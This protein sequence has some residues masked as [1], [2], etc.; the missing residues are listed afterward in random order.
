V[1]GRERIVI[2]GGGFAGLYAAR[3]LERTLP[4][5]RAQVTLVNNRNYML[6]TPQLPEVAAGLIGP[7]DIVVPLREQL[8]RT[9]LRI[10]QVTGA[11]LGR[12]VLSVRDGRGRDDELP[13]DYL[14]VALGSVSRTLPIPGL[15]ERAVGFKTIGEALTLR[16]RVILSLEAAERP[17][18][19]EEERAALLTFVF[20]GGG[21]SGFEA[22]AHMRSY[23]ADL[24]R[25]YPRSA[26][27]GMRWILVE[28]SDRVMHEVPEDL[29]AF[30]AREAEGK[31]VEIRTATRLEAVDDAG[32][33]L[34]DGGA[35][36]TRHVV[37]TAGI[38]PSPAVAELD[39]PLDDHGRIRADSHMRVEGHDRVW[40]VGD[41]AA[42]PDPARPGQ[43]CPQTAQ[44]AMRQGRGVAR[45]VAAALGHGHAVPF[46]FKTVGMFVSL[47]RRDS[48][49]TA[50]GVK[51]R[52]LP[53]YAMG[54]G[55]HLLALPGSGGQ[56]LR[57]LSD[58]AI[59]TAFGRQASQLGV[60]GGT[61][62]FLEAETDVV[63]LQAASG[64][65]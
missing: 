33:R 1:P 29:A 61:H 32:V 60:P 58:A 23:A 9:T 36:A 49:A 51:L 39:L 59:A 35:I 10:G 38:T 2:A 65:S 52:G 24:L 26:R 31:G 47:G 6:Y 17:D 57:I 3:A 44:H 56:R 54:L 19:S 55:Y 37:W 12:R 45:N 48:V 28:G 14:I 5:A 7:L 63:G 42:V 22:I 25:L 13:Y 53:A 62:P 8:R 46:T 18:A 40:A 20:V 11:D 16:N 43:T 34:S 50:R 41:A 15:A 21:Y 64:R 30:A 27:R 4:D